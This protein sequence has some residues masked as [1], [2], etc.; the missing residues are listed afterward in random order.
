MGKDEVLDLSACTEFRQTLQGRPPRIVHGTVLLLATLLGS[1]VA[2]GALTRADLVVRATG[3]VRP[4]SNP[5]KFLSGGR[6][7]VLSAT[8]GGRVAEVNFREGQEVRRGDVLLRLD[9]EKLDHEIARRQRTLRTLEE[10]LTRGERL[11]GLTALQYE[12]ARAKA[13]AELAQAQAEASQTRERQASDA[14][15]ARAELTAVKDEEERL[16][17][18]PRAAVTDADLVKTRA[19]RR[20][21]EEKLA[22]ALLPV[23]ESKAEVLRR[24][25]PVL[26]R[27]HALKSAELDR[28]Q[29]TKQGEIDA[30]RIELS[31]LELERRHGVVRSPMDGVIITGDVKVGDLLEAGKPVAEIAEPAQQGFLFEAAVPSEE[32]GHLRVG[33]PARLRLDAYDY[34]RYGTLQGTVT[35]ISPDSGVPEGQKAAVYLVR[36]ALDGDEVGRGEFRGK[37]K[38]GMAGQVE[39]VTEEESLLLILLKKIRKTISL[40]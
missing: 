20:E 13:E 6:G 35:F 37:V 4:V 15:A 16:Q 29:Q 14:R 12:A 36:I 1:A 26:A 9:T 23:D 18:L 33:M 11:K 8:Q 21:V 31:G 40:G 28:N 10:E 22:K 27:D 30:A 39:I 3:R 17:R 24:A 5:K 32:V 38:L 2:W 25:L 7:E 19:R 34:Q